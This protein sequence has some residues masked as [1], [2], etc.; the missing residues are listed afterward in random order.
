MT[1]VVLGI[2][3]FK[4]RI[5]YSSDP[6]VFFKV[7]STNMAASQKFPIFHWLTSVFSSIFFTYVHEKK[8]IL[9]SLL[10]L[11][12]QIIILLV[13]NHLC[14][15]EKPFQMQFIMDLCA[16]QTL[17]RDIA[18]DARSTH[19]GSVASHFHLLRHLKADMVCLTLVPAL[20]PF[21]LML[22]KGRPNSITRL[23]NQRVR[24]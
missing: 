23:I 13:L 11:Y 3:I 22:M 15:A 7:K 6:S 19:P 18:L 10:C 20:W 12:S 5:Q 17:C 21:W 16:R 14:I 8:S 9:V 24:L 4:L 2:G 1:F